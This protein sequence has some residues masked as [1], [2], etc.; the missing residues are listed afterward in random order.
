MTYEL[1]FHPDALSAWNKLDKPVWEQF[2]KKLNDRLENPRMESARVSG[3]NNLYKIKLRAAGFRLVY[4]VQDQQITVLV[5]SVGKRDRN[6]AYNA[7]L[8]RL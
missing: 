8:G 1:A 7:A 4:Q 2:K 5:L 6:A 3:G